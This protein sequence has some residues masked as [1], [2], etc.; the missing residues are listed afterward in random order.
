MKTLNLL[1]GAAALAL[2]AG[3]AFAASFGDG[4]IMSESMGGKDVLTDAKGMTLYIYDKDTT[5]V[6][7]CYDKCAVNWPPSAQ[8]WS[9][10]SISCR[11]T[12]SW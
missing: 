4:A 1:L 9:R 2:F 6:S 8:T 7:N 3:P 12:A 10:N 5:G 11:S